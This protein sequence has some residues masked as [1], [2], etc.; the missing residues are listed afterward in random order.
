[1]DLH[2]GDSK[3]TDDE[4]AAVDALLGPPE[5]S[6]EGADRSDAD[7]RWAR[8]GREARDRRDLLLPGLHAINDRVGWISEGALDYLCRRL[9][10][11]PAEA[12]GVA[13]FYA[14]FSVKPRPATVLHV[15]TDLACAAAGAPELC[16]GI[17]AR[18]GPGVHVERSPCLGLCE[19]APAALAIR[20]GDPVRTAV[21]AP[22]TVE[23]AVLA[24]TA[25]DSAP[26]E[27]PAA[28]A[29]PQAGGD[30]LILLRRVGVVDPLSLDDYR[31]HGGYTALRRAF[32]LGPAGVIREVTDSGLVGRGG[33]AFPT[34]RK[35]QATASQP[36]HP[37]YVVCNADESEPGTFKDRVLMEGDPY[38]L[39][40]SMT[41]A[42]YATGA[43]QGY[44]Y[45]RGEYPRALHRLEHAIAQ[46]RARGL[47]GDDV[48]GQGYAFDIE[49]R[50]GA[51][52]YICG[53]ETALFN[54]IEGYRGEPRSKPPFPVEKGLFGKPTVE[55]N[56]ETLVNVLPILTMGAP[57]YAAIGTERSTGPKLFCVSGSVE[58]PGIYELPFG[59]TLGELLELAGVRERLRAV[60]LG[61]AAG[62]FVRP[63]E[64]DI[65]LTFEGTREA[66]TTLG[67]GVVMAFD[68]TVPLPRLLLRIAEFFRD[69]SCGQCVP[70]RVGTV[71]QEEALHRIVARTGAAAADD[72][73]LLRDVGRAMRDASICGLGQTAWNAVESAIDRLGAYE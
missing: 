41:I 57:A 47:L 18:L 36:D 29:V 58:R 2:F 45:L 42:A 72:I 71:R 60:L 12:Y 69:E 55:N 52:A 8:G 66:G 56:V 61:G 31:A 24:A 5:S 3:P 34:G 37:H 48:L 17:E 20:A 16:A 14:M 11:P 6:W 49:I 9:T 21:S 30:D 44:L 32:E 13:T 62:G 53:E 43:H 10:V 35:W 54:S 51:G 26:E 73:A 25:P 50:R 27:P 39:I 33:A 15:C 65:P 68:D 46:A 23:G 19:R 28:M 1:M 40:E 70:C 64:R 63:D 59:A 67:S 38:A 22:A 4:R 7:L